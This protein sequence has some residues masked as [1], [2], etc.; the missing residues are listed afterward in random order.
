MTQSLDRPALGIG[1]LLLALFLLAS[2]DAIAKHLSETL[3]LPQIL[4]IRFWVFVVFALAIARRI[5]VV[6]A[7]RSARPA[8]QVLR[9]LVMVGQ[10]SAFIFAFSLMPLANVHAIAAVTPLLVTALAAI[11]LGEPIE[12]RRAAAVGV[13][14][15]GVLVIIR[16]GTG[17]FDPTSVVALG[18]A[19]CWAVFQI[20]LRAV[21]R[22]D[23]PETTTLYSAVI[24][25]ACFSLAVPFV[26]QAPAPAAWTWLISIGVMGSVGHYLLSLAFRYAPASTLQPFAYSMPVWA[27]LL[28]WIVFD[29]VPDIWTVTGGAIVIGS[30]L[31]AL[32]VASRPADRAVSRP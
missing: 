17:V 20:L 21:S 11:F 10:M 9:A 19:A 13:G 18:G 4:A 23:A 12:R 2:I 24:G 5:G 26:W 7:V 6:R 14:F 22:H 32:R 27:A 28:G 1:L 8:L 30:G 3:A 29:H 25:A 16:P 15:L 31:Y